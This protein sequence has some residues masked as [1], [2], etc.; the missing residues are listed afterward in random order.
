[1]EVPERGNWLTANRPELST[2][3]NDY[4]AKVLPF[5]F[6][7]DLNGQSDEEKIA[8]R[9]RLASW[10]DR[11]S[12]P[13]YGLTLQFYC[14][15]QDVPIGTPYNIASYAILAQMLAQC[16]GMVAEELIYMAGDIHIY[17]NQLEGVKIQL[18]REPF[19]FPTLRLNPD[20][21]DIFS[22]KVDDFELIGYQ[23]HPKIDFGDVAV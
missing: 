22:F 15:S 19:P 11:H 12:V 1:M 5:S 6:K 20:V 16:T 21:K 7:H 14:R 10:L 23:H 17:K 3:Y 4:A 9:K 8:A 2:A 18:E 13:R